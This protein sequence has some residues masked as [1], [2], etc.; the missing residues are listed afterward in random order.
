MNH[1]STLSSKTRPENHGREPFIFIPLLSEVEGE[2]RALWLVPVFYN[3]LLGPFREHLALRSVSLYSIKDLS[4]EGSLIILKN[5]NSGVQLP[6]CGNHM[7]HSHT[8]MGCTMY[9]KDQ[10]SQSLFFS[11]NIAWNHGIAYFAIKDFN[12]RNMN[13]KV[14]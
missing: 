1:A 12:H 3:A 5:P 9:K 8:C 2:K 4:G 6:T 10:P 7:P 14:G 11:I 13:V